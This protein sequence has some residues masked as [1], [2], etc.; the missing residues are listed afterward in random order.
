MIDPT[1]SSFPL[2]RRSSL[3]KTNFLPKMVDSTYREMRCMIITCIL[4]TD[5]GSHFQ[6]MAKLEQRLSSLDMMQTADRQLLMEVLVHAGETSAR[7]CYVETYS[8]IHTHFA[9]DLS[10][11]DKF[12]RTCTLHMLLSIS[13]SLSSSLLFS[14]QLFTNPT[15]DSGETMG[16]VIQ[17]VS[18]CL[19]GVLPTRRS[20]GRGRHTSRAIH[21][22]QKVLSGEEHS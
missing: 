1:D 22:P 14:V 7:V 16:T 8:A 9:A 6:L 17:M 20:R 10:N 18:S 19:A 12:N 13:I 11:G 2:F 21:G 5:M 3:Q 4:S 15:C